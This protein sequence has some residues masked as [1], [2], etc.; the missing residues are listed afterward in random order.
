MSIQSPKDVEFSPP[1][2]AYKSVHSGRRSYH[3]HEYQ[4]RLN[5]VIS[6]CNCDWQSCRHHKSSHYQWRLGRSFQCWC[7]D[8]PIISMPPSRSK[9][10]S[11]YRDKLYSHPRLTTFL[12]MSMALVLV[13]TRR[14]IVLSIPSSVSI[15]GK[16]WSR[17]LIY[18]I[19]HSL[20]VQTRPAVELPCC[21][22]YTPTSE[23]G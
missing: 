23:D 1:S 4:L 2:K 8:S 16:N 12:R 21:R 22:F 13:P 6:R 20:K 3:G 18:V 7:S 5:A 19:I 15:W 14:R 11:R 17:R 9:Q 10:Q